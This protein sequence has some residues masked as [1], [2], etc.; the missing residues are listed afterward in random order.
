[1]G[2]SGLPAGGVPISGL[3]LVNS[4]SCVMKAGFP[5]AQ[6]GPGFCEWGSTSVR[7]VRYDWVSALASRRGVSLTGVVMNPDLRFT[8][9]PKVIA[10]TATGAYTIA[11]SV[12]GVPPLRVTSLPIGTV[13][14]ASP[15]PVSVW[16]WLVL[17]GSGVVEY[18]YSVLHWAEA[19]SASCHEKTACATSSVPIVWRSL[20]DPIGQFG[21][22]GS[23]PR[24]TWIRWAQ[25][26]APSGL[27]WMYP[28]RPML[29]LSFQPFGSYS[30]RGTITS[31]QPR[32]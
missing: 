15:T 19:L 14:K 25:E 12:G 4:G 9:N 24:W 23:Y 3:S 20:A 18:P 11:G 17:V 8:L 28:G 31:Q 32:G 13:V 27:S 29:P 16:S 10:D 2:A 30:P 5:C 26:D 22:T 6:A 1:M 7:S 21:W